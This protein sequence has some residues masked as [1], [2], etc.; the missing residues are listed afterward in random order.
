MTDKP[1]SATYAFRKMLPDNLIG[2][3]LFSVGMV[4]RV[5]Y[6]GTVLPLV[7]EMR[8]GY[9]EVTAPKWFGVHNHI[10]TFHAIAACNLAET[11][12]GML[13]EAST[14]STHRWIPKAM[15]TQYLAKAET[16]LTAKAEFAEP[17]DFDDITEGRD[18]VVSISICDTAGK[19]VVHCDITTW[20]T[21]A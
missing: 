20:V 3:A 16:R 17:I 8:P 12:M 13:M 5:P 7:R 1:V 10:G 2:D 15:T 18:V 11:A 9:C 6:F 21:P 14:P 4:A 19:E